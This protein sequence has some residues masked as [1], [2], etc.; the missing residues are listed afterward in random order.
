MYCVTQRQSPDFDITMRESLSTV[1]GASIFKLTMGRFLREVGG[2][3]T[4]ELTT[5]R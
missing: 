1:G 3:Q 5:R 4:Y 2:A